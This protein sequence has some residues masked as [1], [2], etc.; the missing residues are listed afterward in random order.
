MFTLKTPLKKGSRKLINAWAFYDWANSVYP[1]V[2]SSAI[3]P[4]YYGSLF[5]ENNMISFFQY[6]IKNTAMISFVTAAAF[7]IVAVISPLLS[8]IADYIGNKKRFM[9]IF[10]YLGS[11]SC[12]GLYFF[13]LDS[14]YLGFFIYFLG[15][16]GYWSSLVFY[17]SYLPDIAF[18]DEQDR[19]SALGFSVGYVGSVLLL[20]SN[21][22]MVMK[23]D[24]FGISGTE[25]EA[26]M[27]AMRYSF[28]SAGVWWLVF[29]QI[30]FYYL[31]RGNREVKVTKDIFWNG[32]KELKSV[33]KLLEY[34]TSIKRFLPA[35][36]LYSMALQTVLLVAAYFGEEEIEWGSA[37]AKTTGLIVSIL[38]IQ[39][40]GIIGA[41]LTAKAS[42]HFGN[43]R[44]LIVINFIWA[45]L[46]FYAY[47]IHTPI[48]FYTVA[49]MVG[50]VMGGLQALSR[51]TYSKLIP[52]TEDTTSFFSFYDV[53][54]K[55]GII[56]GMSLFGVIDQITGSM[57]NAILVF[58]IFFIAGALM[59]FR[60]PRKNLS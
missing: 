29:S 2:I 54:E 53:T 11:I 12:V 57:R 52:K 43:L 41:I 6:E 18:K 14:I 55:I 42:K 13:E 33:W 27:T 28:V 17:N 45:G 4:V 51:S 37:G 44:V 5:S 56:I 58:M 10:V 22:A 25:S 50:M 46:C 8:G 21:L 34:N 38:L 32:Y 7:L 59:L 48:E 16:I 30:S 47:H 26:A 39:L 23:P 9:K 31:P 35:F 19:V 20:L 1:L 36:Y 15:L 24:I 49:G 3:F 40:V 60:V